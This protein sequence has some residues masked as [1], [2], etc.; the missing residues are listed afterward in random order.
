MAFTVG[1]SIKNVRL[2]EES[3]VESDG[4]VRHI[5]IQD[6]LWNCMQRRQHLTSI[7]DSRVLALHTFFDQVTLF[8]SS[9]FDYTKIR[10]L[11]TPDTGDRILSDN[12]ENFLNVYQ[13]AC[14]MDQEFQ[15]RF[16][17]A[18]RD[19]SSDIIDIQ[20]EEG[21]GK[22]GMKL[23]FRN[24]PFWLSEVSDG[25]VEA[26]LMSLLL[27]LPS[28]LAP[29]VLCLDEPELSLHPAWQAKLAR[30]IQ[31]SGSFRQCFISTHS[32]DFLDSFTEGFRRGEV[33]ILVCGSKGGNRI[34]R[35][36]PEK[37]EPELSKGWMLG[38][39][40]RVNDPLIGGWPY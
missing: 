21:L 36:E 37:L 1:E 24:G 11:Q 3:L 32:P 22:I 15:F 17:N 29:T 38:D 2:T 5:S 4:A 27:T 14:G 13:T 12:G 20:L 26:L 18:M 19:L 9:S 28:E 7:G 10:Q 35:L 30:Q 39:L 16:L 25:T 6:G 31:M 33:G 40:Y 8:L 34:E 23:V